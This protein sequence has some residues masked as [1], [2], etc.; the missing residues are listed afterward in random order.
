M[1]NSHNLPAE[2]TLAV[3]RAYRDYLV[4][5]HRARFWTM[6]SAVAVILLL[7]YFYWHGSGFIYFYMPL[8]FVIGYSNYKASINERWQY[9]IDKN[10]IRVMW[11]QMRKSTWFWRTVGWRNGAVVGVQHQKWQGWPAL[12]VLVESKNPNHQPTLLLVYAHE[13]ADTVQNVVLP[14]IESYRQQY[15]HPLWADTLRQE[16]P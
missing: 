7:K 8:M 14:L 15:R 5:R 9:T 6:W 12:R 13:D 2:V 11:W 16:K 3:P 1:L 10:G 4:R